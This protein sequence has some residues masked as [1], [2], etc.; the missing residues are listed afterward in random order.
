MAAFVYKCPI[1]GRNVQGWVADDGDIKND[2][3]HPVKCI[4]C[5][6]VHLVNP[7]SRKVLGANEE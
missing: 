6:R 1:T 2:V 4:A 3:H 5:Q 7:N